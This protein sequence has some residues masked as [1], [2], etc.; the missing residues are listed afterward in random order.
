LNIQLEISVNS[1]H[2]EALL[3]FRGSL[4]LTQDEVG[5]ALRLGLGL[6]NLGLGSAL[7]LGFELGIGPAQGL[8]R[9][10]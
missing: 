2:A 7:R 5:P 1:Y 3:N 10:S 9:P 4:D 6:V 8:M